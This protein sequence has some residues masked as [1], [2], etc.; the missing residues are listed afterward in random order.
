MIAALLL[1]VAQVPTPEPVPVALRGSEVTASLQMSATHFAAQSHTHEVQWVLF[2]NRANG[3][4]TMRGLAPFGSLL[5]PIGDD[6][7]D[8][9]VVEVLARAESGFLA[10]CGVFDCKALVGKT[11]FLERRTSNA[12]GWITERSGRALRRA[13]G[14]EVP[15]LTHVPVPLPSENKKKDK[16]RRIEKKKLPPF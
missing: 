2:A 10:T 8:D 16:S 3:L 13:S 1:T 11:L 12:V 15:S 6:A 9:V 7:A 4:R 14:S 5:Y